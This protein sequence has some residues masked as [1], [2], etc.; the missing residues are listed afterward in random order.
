M[1]RWRLSLG[2]LLVATLVGLCWMDARAERPG[3]WLLPLA[4]LISLL[5]SAEM[6]YL[7]SARGL[8]PASWPIYLGNLTLVLANLQNGWFGKP[9]GSFPSWPSHVFAICVLVVFL[10]E[11]ARYRAPGTSTEQL[12]LGILAIAYVGWLLTFVIQ[13]RL[14]GGIRALVSLIAIVKMCDTGAYTVGRLIGRHKLV[15]VLSPGKTIEGAIGGLLFALVAS[16]CVFYAWPA[17]KS[18]ANTVTTAWWGWL[19]YGLLVGVAGILGDLAESL[20][21]RDLGRKDSSN[22]LPGFGGVLDI[23]DSILLAAPVAYIGWQ[24]GWMGGP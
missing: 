12:A 21:K 23:M 10:V 11:M 13:L 15:P 9:A 22:W 19:A 2:T 4:G 18:P 3:T 14:L 16:A 8:R 1:L 17:A 6:L 24:L 7:F 5:A 20:L